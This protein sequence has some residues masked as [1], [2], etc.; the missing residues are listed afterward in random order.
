M[1][2]EH[3]IDARRQLTR[4]DPKEYPAERE[5]REGLRVEPA[6]VPRILTGLY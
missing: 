3:S 2:T 6:F 5:A 1:H 4:F